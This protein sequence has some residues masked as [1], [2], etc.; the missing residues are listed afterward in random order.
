MEPICKLLENDA[1]VARHGQQHLAKILSL[2]FDLA[3]KFDL[4]QLRQAINQ[5]RHRCAKTLDQF[6]LLDVLVFHDVVQ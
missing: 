3:L 4:L 5:G 2:R 1:H 6:I